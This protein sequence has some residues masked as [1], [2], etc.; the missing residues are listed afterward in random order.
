ML[1]GLRIGSQVG[2]R[3]RAQKVAQNS[4]L[5]AE[6]RAAAAWTVWRGVRAIFVTGAEGI[7]EVIENA[8][9]GEHEIPGLAEVGG[10]LVAQGS[11]FVIRT[12]GAHAVVGEHGLRISVAK[13]DDAY[14]REKSSHG[15]VEI[16]VILGH[17]V[18]V[19][20]GEMPLRW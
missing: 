14:A 3:K 18:L 1:D 11:S 2:E 5:Q 7:V 15:R 13:I 20:T 6:C 12:G 16:A 10:V 17:K 8:P 4:K 9:A 19:G